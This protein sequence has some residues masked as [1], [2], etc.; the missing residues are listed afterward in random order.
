[1]TAAVT[2]PSALSY[3]EGHFVASSEHSSVPSCRVPVQ[4]AVTPVPNEEGMPL[5]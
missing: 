2:A 4:M 1:M 5:P 3:L